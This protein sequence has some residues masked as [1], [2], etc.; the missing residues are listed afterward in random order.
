LACADVAEADD[1][2]VLAESDEV[3]EQEDVC[4]E[5]EVEAE[6]VSLGDRFQELYSEFA[7][8][9]ATEESE[10]EESEEFVAE[11]N[12]EAVAEDLGDEPESIEVDSEQEA[13]PGEKTLFGYAIADVF[14]ADEETTETECELEQ[15]EEP[16][17]EADS[18]TEEVDFW[19][20]CSSQR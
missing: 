15:E 9:E 19:T 16:V 8:A 14:A 3:T 1:A 10:D 18:V 7:D 17:L 5:T 4:A 2:E 11:E 13:A 20:A 12:E 6:D